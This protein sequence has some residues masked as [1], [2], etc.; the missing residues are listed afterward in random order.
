MLKYNF[1]RV[2]KA[3]VIDKP[4]T[5]LKTAGFSVNFASKVK[6]NRISR[7]DMH[8]LERLCLLLKCTPNDLM[9]WTPDSNQ[10][11][12]EEQPLNEMRERGV[13]MVKLINSI[14]LGQLDNIER[15]IKDELHKS[16]P[17][18]E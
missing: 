11:V 10:D 15:L 2:F 14:P 17:E 13:D 4:F 9:V 6:N 18:K 8:L 16:N 7:L 5:F 1:Q 12:S 3:R